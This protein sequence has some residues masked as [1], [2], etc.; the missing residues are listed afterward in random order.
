VSNYVSPIIPGVTH[1]QESEI[2]RIAAAVRV[3]QSSGMSATG[4]IPRDYSRQPLGSIHGTSSFP[5]EL[6]LDDKQ[7]KERIEE[8]ERTKTDLV[9][10]LQFLWANKQWIGLN[11]DPT[12]Y[13]WCFAVIHA[14]MILRALSGEPFKRLSPFSVACI[15]KAFR[16]NG[17]WGGEANEQCVKEG[18]ATEEFWPF[19]IP[20]S[21]KV[22][23]ANMAAF[24]RKYLATSRANA[25]L[26]KV[27]E[28]WE[29]EPNNDQQKLSALCIPL[30][31]ASGY[32]RI[33]H[34]RCSV[35]AT[36]L[37]NG[38]YG[39]IDLDSYTQDGSP[40][41]KSFA[42][43]SLPANDAV[44]PRVISPSNT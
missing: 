41:L 25:A 34:E 19:G 8:L 33:G 28:F 43:S 11:Q 2:A 38:A 44:I 21:G 23:S 32:N 7:I 12:N 9:S 17:G 42:L 4:Y 6:L 13:C 16:N 30:P 31:V 29:L 22:Q 37:S 5:T 35:K 3:N 24:D 40:D 10:L 1:Q 27:T 18:V 14:I 20:G 26:H 39:C 36:L 15:V